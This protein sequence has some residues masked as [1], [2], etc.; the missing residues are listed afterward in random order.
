MYNPVDKHPIKPGFEPSTSESRST[1]GP[2]EPSGPAVKMYKWPDSVK[3]QG[4]T[5]NYQA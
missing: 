1:A 4:L 5:G 2:N 3:S